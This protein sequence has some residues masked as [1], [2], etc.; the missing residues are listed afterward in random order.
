MNGVL[1]HYWSRTA[2]GY[3]E[4]LEQVGLHLIETCHDPRTRDTYYLA[5]KI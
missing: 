5:E 3:R 2:E 1:F 4:L